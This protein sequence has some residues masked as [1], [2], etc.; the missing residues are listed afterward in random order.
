MTV[1]PVTLAVN[2][3]NRTHRLFLSFLQ[4]C[5]EAELHHNLSA[6]SHSIAWH[7]WHLARWADFVQ[8]SIPGMTPELGRRIGTGVQIWYKDDLAARWGFKADDLGFDQTGMWMSD[9]AAVALKFPP[10]DALLDYVQH[11]FAAM[12]QALTHVDDEQFVSPEQIQPMTQDIWAEGPV[13]KVILEHSS[14]ANRHLGMAECI[15]GLQ[16]KPGTATK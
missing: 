7:A 6:S 9:E 14:H 2:E 1:S 10:K 3:I 13:G 12:E 8:A 16:G 11:A 4:K 15:L 5:S